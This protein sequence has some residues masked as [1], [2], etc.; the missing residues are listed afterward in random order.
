MKALI[1]RL[2]NRLPRPALSKEQAEMLASIK[3]PCC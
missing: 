1:S 2:L 3:F